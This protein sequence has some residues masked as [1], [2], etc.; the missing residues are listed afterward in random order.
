MICENWTKAIRLFSELSRL[1]REQAEA[2]G[3]AVSSN[4]W[5]VRARDD[6]P[7]L[8]IDDIHS[9]LEDLPNNYK[10][11]PYLDLANL[12]LHKLL[13]TY[14]NDSNRDPEVAPSATTNAK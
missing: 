1:E 7:V 13:D 4:T 14:V 3:V 9:L 10:D 6:A 11:I 5:T 2:N 8:S 12:L